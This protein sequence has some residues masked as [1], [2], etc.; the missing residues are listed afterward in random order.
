M[1]TEIS[2][3]LHSLGQ[4]IRRAKGP[5]FTDA[6]YGNALRAFIG[7]CHAM[8]RSDRCFRAKAAE[9]ERIERERERERNR[10]V[11]GED[12]DSILGAWESSSDV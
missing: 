5:V 6:D 2:I 7:I 10:L 12:L 3:A 8:D 11:I 4:V 9:A 1:D